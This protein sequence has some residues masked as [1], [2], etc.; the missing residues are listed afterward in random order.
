MKTDKY[1]ELI[2][3]NNPQIQEAKCLPSKIKIN[4][5]SVEHTAEKESK[6]TKILRA[7]RMKNRLHINEWQL[8]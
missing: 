5:I 4:S 1:P 6:K 2:K 3:D 7:V 8:N